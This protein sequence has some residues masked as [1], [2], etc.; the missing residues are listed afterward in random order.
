MS[1]TLFTNDKRREYLGSN[2]PEGRVG[3]SLHHYYELSATEEASASSG[4]DDDEDTHQTLAAHRMD[5]AYSC[6]IK[7]GFISS[8][9]ECKCGQAE[10]SGRN[11]GDDVEGELREGEES[12]KDNPEEQTYKEDKLFTQCPNTANHYISNDDHL[13]STSYGGKKG[14]HNRFTHGRYKVVLFGGGVPEEAFVKN[15]ANGCSQGQGDEENGAYSKYNMMSVENSLEKTFN[16]L[17]ICEEENDDFENWVNVKTHNVPEARAFHASCI[18]NLGLTGVFLFIHGGKVKNDMLAD[19]RLCA[20]NLSRITYR[21]GR[22]RSGSRCSVELEAKDESDT[23]DNPLAEQNYEHNQT[24][25]N[26]HPDESEGEHLPEDDPLRENEP[27]RANNVVMEEDRNE[28]DEEG[29][30][31]TNEGPQ[32][33]VVKKLAEEE[34][35]EEEEEA[36]GEHLTGGSKNGEASRGEDNLD[37]DIDPASLKEETC[38]D[39]KPDAEKLGAPPQEQ[40]VAANRKK[41]KW[42]CSSSHLCSASSGSVSSESA[43]SA[44]VSP[45]SSSSSS[46]SL[47]PCDSAFFRSSYYRARDNK[48]DEDDEGVL[49]NSRVPAKSLLL[50]GNNSS[51]GSASS[52][53]DSDEDTGKNKHSSLKRVKR[54]WVHIQTV[55]RKPNSRYGHTL[56]FLYPH[57]VLFGGNENVCDDEETFFCKNDLWVLN[58]KKGKTKYTKNERKKI[59][60]FQWQEVEYQS[61][62]PLGRYF[63]ATTVW[64]DV[65][66][67]MNNLIL[68]GGKMRKK[69][70]VSNRLLT[71]QYYGNKWR[72]SILPVYVNPLNENRACHA[73]VCAQNHIF[74]IGGEEYTYKYIE[75]MPSALYSFESK[76]FQYINDFSAK[77]CLKCFA[78]NETIY[79]WGGF[80]D[81]S[82]NQ[83]FLPNN[84]VT[85]DVN[86]HVMYI[87]MKEDLA[88]EYDENNN[89]VVKEEPESD[90]DI[91]NRMNKRI[92]KI[93]NR[94]MELEK[95]LLYQ[96]KLNENLNFRIKS[97]M[98]QYQRLVHLLNVKQ[99]QNVHLIN[100]FKQQSLPLNDGS[101]GCTIAGGVSMC[102]SSSHTLP[103]S[104]PYDVPSGIH[105]IAS[106]DLPHGS[107][108]SL[109]AM[110]LYEPNPSINM[111]TTYMNS[112]NNYGHYN[113]E[114][115]LKMS[116]SP[117]DNFA[118]LMT[119]NN[120]NIH[121]SELQ[122]EYEK[123]TMSELPVGDPDAYNNMLSNEKGNKDVEEQLRFE[124]GGTADRSGVPINQVSAAG[125]NPPCGGECHPSEGYPPPCEQVSSV[126]V[127]A[128]YQTF[129]GMS[130]LCA[131]NG[132]QLQLNERTSGY[133]NAAGHPYN[134]MNQ[135]SDMPI[136]NN[137]SFVND[138]CTW[139][140]LDVSTTNL[141][142]SDSNAKIDNPSSTERGVIGNEKEGSTVTGTN[143]ESVQNQV[144]AN[145]VNKEAPTQ[146]ARRK[147]AAKCLQLIEQD[148]LNRMMSEK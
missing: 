83:I 29:D 103:S 61:V 112:N 20:L 73:L 87:Q 19:D 64:Y 142:E 13:G 138:Y 144:E 42:A 60:Y 92:L 76:K 106:H 91:Y 63:H 66:N 146:R 86:P 130:E 40:N 26:D 124:A 147:T 84:F 125:E 8:Q 80:T 145:Y 36:L 21:G 7:S 95:D 52:E 37:V 126:S 34:M 56:D 28:E 39:A 102:H 111:S 31:P 9:Q 54:T 90:D 45:S 22:N 118:H 6:A 77:A 121:A 89:L 129:N 23:S 4:R 14:Y 70:S 11:G 132:G 119:P 38:S 5:D 116:I 72:W 75:K 82:C 97:Q 16:D 51:C 128:P 117:Q 143:N 127:N 59:L 107:Y 10:I 88:D 24:D 79:S 27:D 81:V 50:R 58:I 74:I 101:V 2:R 134:G 94:K 71:L 140:P 135:P 32:N 85:I 98:V 15:Y 49:V 105:H 148:R 57:L 137:T 113:G 123:Q 68:Y 44:F 104:I 30:D 3:H 65:E 108:H 100:A 139:I 96:I 78:K 122:G 47:P 1:L 17:Y 110:P 18:V 133:S 141:Q 93:Q 12:P 115:F 48:F 43:S 35:V 120:M 69:T 136:P 99:S 55:G 25:C 67:K 46:N 109:Q 62:N 131:M 53:E 33:G 114:D 41:R